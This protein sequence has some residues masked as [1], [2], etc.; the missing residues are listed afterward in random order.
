[1]KKHNGMRKA[2]AFALTLAM[3]AGLFVPG[4]QA[5]A[6][7]EKETLTIGLAQNS[8]VEDYET[9][10]LTQLIEQECNVNL[11]FVYLPSAVDDAK[12]KFAIMASSNTTL[13]DVVVVANNQFTDLEI[14]DYG[15]KGI[16]IPLNEYLENKD[17]AVNFSQIP[18]EDQ[19][20][21][22]SASTSPDGNI[23]CLTQNTPEDWN[24]TPFRFW[25][26]KAW[27]EKLNLET[28]TTTDEFYEVMKAFVEQD[29]NGNGTADEIGITG[30]TDGWGCNPAYYIMNSF[31]F[32][33]GDQS[34]GGLALDED[35]TE[36]TAP[37][38]SEGWKAGLEYMN[39]LCSEGILSPA[40]FTQDATQFTSVLSNETQITG[41]CA[42]GGFG[43]WSGAQEN[44]NFQEMELLAPLKGPEGIA[45]AAYNEYTP[46][47]AYLITKDCKN[48]ELA[49]KVGDFFYRNDV[50]LTV[51][52]GEE[53]VDWTTD[54]EK[55][56][57]YKGLYEDLW[58]IPCSLVQLNTV[59]SSVQNKHWYN[60]GPRYTSLEN[61]RGI[62]SDQMAGSDA[63]DYTSLTRQQSAEYY[64]E[65][66]PE[67]VLPVL[68]YT[69]DEA[70]KLAEIQENVL[71][72]VKQSLA[73]FVTGNRPLSDWDN[74]LSDLE[75]MGLQ[76][77]LDVAQ[78]AY[79]RI[80][81]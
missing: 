53:G 32:Y 68:K 28:P 6:G 54:A 35:G 56:K 39:K 58:D 63:V 48:P 19:E 47:P 71:T 7:E 10:Y 4:T 55:C 74:Y 12:S 22:I 67:K 70:E 5:E 80:E 81:K 50:S 72:Y 43:Y 59:W 42:A 37:F 78:T 20:K 34:N 66:H 49:F 40:M 79:D 27:L 52:Y 16:F 60:V 30:C 24:M 14:A 18:E 69:N 44:A 77:W 64:M 45:Y 23:Y 61:Y 15:S 65:A 13:P 41:S 26:N 38:A 21:M 76:E 2:T 8:N 62:N 3:T 25:I 51:R 1:M 31:V 33:N 36:V 17:L 73:E 46:T 9:N 57:E 75:N 11:E 29:P